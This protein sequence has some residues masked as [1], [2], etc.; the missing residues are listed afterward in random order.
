MSFEANALAI[1]ARLDA[2]P[3]PTAAPII[4]VNETFDDAD[5]YIRVRM[6]DAAATIIAFGGSRHNTNRHPGVLQISVFTPLGQGEGV[7]LR[8]AQETGEL[9]GNT[10]YA[11]MVFDPYSIWRFGED[12]NHMRHDVSIP[13][14]WDE[15]VI[16]Q[17]I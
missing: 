15:Q 10:R 11:G 13:Y 8:L 7:G 5:E 17:D 2:W 4:G 16:A 6:L 3:N 12:E 14:Y 9:F 1:L